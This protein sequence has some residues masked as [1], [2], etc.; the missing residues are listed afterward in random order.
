MIPIKIKAKCF[1]VGGDS[2]K[3]VRTVLRVDGGARLL[4]STRRATNKG[5]GISRSAN[6]SEGDG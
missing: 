5:R 2:R 4:L 1:T 3:V 6:G